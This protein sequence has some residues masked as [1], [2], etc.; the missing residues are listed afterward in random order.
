MR[1]RAVVNAA[2]DPDT[3]GGQLEQKIPVTPCVTETYA[4]S[5]HSSTIE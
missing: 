3:L 2:A 4:L 5:S 1:R